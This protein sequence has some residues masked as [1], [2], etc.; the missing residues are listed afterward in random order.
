MQA[1]QKAIK[2]LPREEKPISLV[3]YSLIAAIAISWGLA[4]VAMK[5]V[6]TDAP[7]LE[8]AAIRFVLSALPLLLVS[9]WTGGLKKLKRADFWKFAVLGLFQTTLL[10]GIA[11]VVIG[12]TAAGITSVLM[13]TNPFFVALF[14]HFLIAGERLTRRKGLGLL[15]GFCGVLALVLGGAG[16]GQTELQWPALI[17]ISS[18][19]WAFSS[20]L[21]KLFKFSDMISATAWQAIFGSI[22]LVLLSVIFEH[23]RSIHW[24]ASFI[25]WMFYLAFI[26]SSFGWWAWNR[27]LQKYS[28][29]RISVFLFLVPVCGVLC[30]VLFLGETLGLNVIIGGGLVAAGIYIVNKRRKTLPTP[31]A[32]STEAV[33]PQTP[34]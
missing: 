19:S 3:D 27:L 10:F 15:I 4:F 7:P 25:L 16:L 34:E 23:D 13:N 5:R 12:N 2:V 17:M 22:P 1:T 29:S 21:V 6:I 26:A 24:T 32:M 31:V 28:A 14:A 30:G 18:V 9:Y 8:S 20:I 33:A 11:F